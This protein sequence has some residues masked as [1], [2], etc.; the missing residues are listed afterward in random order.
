M[1]P[2]E[3]IIRILD[4]ILDEWE[5][6]GERNPLHIP[7]FKFTKQD[8]TQDDVEKVVE[9]IKRKK[10]LSDVRFF[11]DE[12]NGLMPK[13]APTIELKLLKLLELNKHRNELSKE[14]ELEIGALRG[15]SQKFRFVEGILYRDFEN[16]ILDFTDAKSQRDLLELAF[17]VPLKEWIEAKNIDTEVSRG[18]EE[19]GF[20]D[21]ANN[22]NKKIRAKFDFQDKFFELDKKNNMCRRMAI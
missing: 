4:V 21:A 15:I 11:I 14:S 12:G 8:V 6:A 2:K 9:T 18:K 1:F 16:A 19:R 5:V 20:Y 10:W 7:I 13:I 17:A 22:I 3:K